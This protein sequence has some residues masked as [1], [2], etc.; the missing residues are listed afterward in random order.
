MTY[1]LFCKKKK[2]VCVKFS[3]F[4]LACESFPRGR[5]PWGTVL[6]Y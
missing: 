2:V 5:A 3:N 1:F 4:V 6:R